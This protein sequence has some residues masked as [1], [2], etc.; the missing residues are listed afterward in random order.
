MLKC[1]VHL[2]VE[3]PEVHGVITHGEITWKKI[4][5][6]QEDQIEDHQNQ[7]ENILILVNIKIDQEEL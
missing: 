1:T 6:H 3:K 4:K 2:V 5:N 7:I